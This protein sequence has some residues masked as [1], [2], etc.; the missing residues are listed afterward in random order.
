[1]NQSPSCIQNAL[2]KNQLVR[3]FTKPQPHSTYHS[4]F[5][6]SLPNS[7][8]M[9]SHPSITLNE[10]LLLLFLLIFHLIHFFKDRYL[11]PSTLRLEISSGEVETHKK[12]IEKKEIR[13][14]SKRLRRGAKL[15]RHFKIGGFRC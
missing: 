15:P 10:P 2:L 12:R 7:F 6:C 13:F 8:K 11:S 5:F 9:Y 1:M 3:L 4:P 14:L